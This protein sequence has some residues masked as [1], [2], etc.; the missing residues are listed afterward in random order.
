MMARIHWLLMVVAAAA[1]SLAVQGGGAKPVWAGSTATKASAIRTAPDAFISDLA[2]RV[3]ALLKDASLSSADRELRL[4]ELARQTFDVEGITR[5]L[6][7]RA[8]RTASDDER[9]AF[10]VLLE[11][12]I[13]RVYASRVGV[14]DRAPT[15]VI[16]AVRPEGDAS[17]VVSEFVRPDGPPARAEWRVIKTPQFELYSNEF[18]KYWI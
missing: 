13:L 3:F 15:F 6:A 4:R 10:G 7:G 9:K 12:Y 11:D 17:V 2:N 5:F 8:W 16:R 18:I 14:I 1:V